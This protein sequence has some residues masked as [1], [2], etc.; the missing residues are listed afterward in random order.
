MR[1]KKFLIFILLLSFLLMG[2]VNQEVVNNSVDLGTDESSV[3]N[4]TDQDLVLST[5]EVKDAALEWR[6]YEDAVYKIGFEYP[7][8]W[9]L[10]V[11]ELPGEV[12]S[13]VSKAVT[14]EKDAVVM[15]IQYEPAGEEIALFSGLG[16]GEVIEEGAFTFLDQGCMLNKLIYEGKTK[17]VWCSAE[18]EDENLFISISGSSE[19]AYEDFDLSDF[20]IGEAQAI[21]AT[22]YRTGLVDFSGY[23]NEVGDSG[24]TTVYDDGNCGMVAR[25][26]VDGQARVTQGL[27]NALRSLPGKGEESVVLGMLEAGSI[28]AVMEGP[29]CA[30]GYFWWKVNDGVRVGWTAEGENETYWIVPYTPD[31]IVDGWVGTIVSAEEM[32]EVDD[33]FQLMNQN[34]SRYGIDGND[35]SIRANLATYRDTGVVLQIWGTLYN[36]RMDA[37]NTQIVVDSFEEF[38]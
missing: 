3:I 27:P 18:L 38:E 19:L 22:I 33:Y 7:P 34:G 5:E 8:E 36:D 24:A 30:D 31:Q 2:C 12:F 26:V 10:V 20:V 15:V 25:L 4:E 37:Y 17:M 29:V 13:L 21:L 16:A 28:V 32:A 6:V 35:D 23:L 11:K 14:L 1:E 9:N